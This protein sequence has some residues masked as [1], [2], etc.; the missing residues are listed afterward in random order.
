MSYTIER[1]IID[2][3]V[4]SINRNDTVRNALELMLRHDYSQ[5]PVVDDAG[6]LV[7]MISEQSITRRYFHVDGKVSLFDLEVNHCQMPAV[8]LRPDTEVFE[9]LGQLRD[10]A[11]AVVVEERKP[12]GVLT[13][14]DLTQFFRAVSE[15]IMIVEDIE[16]TLRQYL[17]SVFAT[18]G[19]RIAAMFRAFGHHKQDETK[20]AKHY[21]RL[22]FSETMS[23]IT[24]DEN[25]P[26]F[27]QYL[28][29]R[30]LFRCSMDRVREIRNQIAHFR[31]DVDKLQ[32]EALIQARDWLAVRPRPVVARTGSAAIVLG[33]VQAQ[34]T[35]IAEKTRSEDKYAPLQ[36]WLEDQPADVT[37]VRVEIAEI[38]RIIGE[39]LPA[40]ASNHRSWWANDSVGHVQSQTWLQAGWRVD[41]VDFVAGMVLFER[42]SEANYQA[43]H[44]GLIKRLQSL[45][46]PLAK[47]PPAPLRSYYNI[48]ADV[49]HFWYGWYFA[50][51]DR[52]RLELYID[53][54]DRQRNKEYFAL[55]Q[56]HQQQIEEQ[57]GTRLDW[58][59]LDKR[60][61][62]RVAW[63]RQAS[64]SDS[65]EELETV[66]D[67]AAGNLPRF[68]A[69]LQPY[70]N[71]VSRD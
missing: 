21:D 49:P 37:Q 31:D 66:I 43:F 64:I 16:V 63:T 36:T 57:L 4:A 48:R 39:P 60:R 51:G 15:G 46:L 19:Q 53:T 5:L 9:A 54:G 65:P 23:L 67:W 52:F 58:E 33:A 69:T 55:L 8:T 26:Y 47:L 3:K 17:D 41:D 10:V 28:K 30:D 2:Q 29:P 61:A 1:L 7:G 24:H 20:P 12:V 45:K 14:F 71:E 6:Y 18:D 62:S 35:A 42:S 50:R 44:A 68:I 25:W 40:S 32:M 70:V 11:A 13:Y 38:E 59:R 34:A 27:E 22:S 56:S